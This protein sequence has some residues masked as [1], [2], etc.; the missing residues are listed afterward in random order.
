MIIIIIIIIKH[1]W[2]I[3]KHCTA[4]IQHYNL[5]SNDEFVKKNVEKISINN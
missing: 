1:I 4:P 2:Q 3:D 5:D